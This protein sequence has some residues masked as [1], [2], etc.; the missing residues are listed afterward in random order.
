[1]NGLEDAI[2][3]D[4]RMSSGM[5]LQMPS[6]VIVYRSIRMSLRLTVKNVFQKESALQNSVSGGNAFQNKLL[7]GMLARIESLGGCVPE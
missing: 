1:M 6:K 2:Q 4:D 3:R 7:K 5:G